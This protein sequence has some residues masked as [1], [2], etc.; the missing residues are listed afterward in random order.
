MMEITKYDIALYREANPGHKFIYVFFNNKEYLFRTLTR[1]EYNDILSIA[2]DEYEIEDAVVQVALLYPDDIV[3]ANY[4]YGGF[5]SSIAPTIIEQSTV[6][7][8]DELYDKYEDAKEY[9][10]IFEQK[11]MCIIK[12]AF[13]EYDFKLIED[14]T[15]D[16]TLLMLARA[17]D[18]LK[19]K[20]P[21]YTGLSYDRE[22]GRALIEE[23]QKSKINDKEFIFSLRQEEIDPMEYFAKELITQDELVEF[24]LIGG[25]HWNNEVVIDGVKRQIQRGYN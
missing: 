2:N 25:R 21:N 6:R 8:S 11:V 17:E 16:H 14:W 9:V 7:D 13:P 19:I 24:P 20:Y 15:W 23:Q 18:I 4:Q 22:K 5:S 10:N 3:F 12:A 1:K